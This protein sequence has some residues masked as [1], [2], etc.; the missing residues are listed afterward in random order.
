MI[1][2]GVKHHVYLPAIDSAYAIYRFSNQM[3]PKIKGLIFLVEG[4]S[5]DELQYLP[6]YMYI[7][8]SQPNTR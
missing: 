1:S 8:H 4:S 2:V 6:V 7:L 5:C 3:K